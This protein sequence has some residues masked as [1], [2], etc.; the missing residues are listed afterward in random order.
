VCVEVNLVPILLCLSC[1]HSFNVFEKGVSLIQGPSSL[2]GQSCY[3]FADFD[4]GGFLN[5]DGPR[6]RANKRFKVFLTA[7]F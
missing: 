4:G 1:Q 7:L 5:H 2:A 3:L 6:L